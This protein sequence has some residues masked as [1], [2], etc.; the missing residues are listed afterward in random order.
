MIAG[1]QHV[2]VDRNA[3]ER[4]PS[5]Q[6][7]R[8]SLIALDPRDNST[9]GQA[10]Q[11]K[12]KGASHSPYAT[13][14]NFGQIR[15]FALRCCTPAALSLAEA[16]RG[17]AS[18]RYSAGPCRCAHA[19]RSVAS[20]RRHAGAPHSSTPRPAFRPLYGPLASAVLHPHCLSGGDRRGCGGCGR[21]PDEPSHSAP[22]PDCRDAPCAGA[23]A[24]VAPLLCSQGQHRR[25]GRR[26][27]R[28]APT[29]RRRRFTMHRAPN[30]HLPVDPLHSLHTPP[31]PLHTRSTISSSRRHRH[32]ARPLRT[33]RVCAGFAVDACCRGG[34]PRSAV[35]RKAQLHR[36]VRSVHRV[37]RRGGSAVR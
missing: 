24:P 32:A 25:R 36:H 11:S 16:G 10:L 30:P 35:R 15:Q 6:R 27:E 26:A 13:T 12:A 8:R 3:C 7:Q 21:G 1:T 5:V 9:P 23:I 2:E 31:L 14:P 18:A 37:A 4:W 19:Y 22:G 29:Q 28:T 20:G 34:V 33:V 17:H